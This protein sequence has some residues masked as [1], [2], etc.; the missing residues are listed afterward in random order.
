MEPNAGDVRAILEHALAP[1]TAADGCELCV[2]EAHAFDF[3]VLSNNLPP[4][5]DLQRTFDAEIDFLTFNRVEQDDPPAYLLVLKELVNIDR[6]LSDTSREEIQKALKRAKGFSEIPTE[7]ATALN[8]EL[9][10]SA[11][12]ILKAYIAYE[13][14]FHPTYELPPTL[15]ARL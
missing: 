11:D 6:P 7:E 13:D 5:G 15:K 8:S 12:P 14:I 4:G 1:A 9:H 10:R 2:F 3:F